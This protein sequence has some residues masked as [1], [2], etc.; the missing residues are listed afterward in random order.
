M[1]E[2]TL[3]PN[4]MHILTTLTVNDVDFTVTHGEAGEQHG[5]RA[6]VV[7]HYNFINTA[8]DNTLTSLSVRIE[9]GDKKYGQL[10][11]RV[12]VDGDHRAVLSR[13]KIYDYAELHRVSARWR[14]S[15]TIEKGILRSAS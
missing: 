12:H 5:V 6:A 10:V 1:T 7:A 2:Q 13:D 15:A 11:S 4:L 3:V 14:T 9:F 8:N